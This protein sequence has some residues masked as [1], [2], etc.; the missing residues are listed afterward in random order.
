LSFQPPPPQPLEPFEILS[1]SL[2]WRRHIDR[3]FP[4]SGAYYFPHH[5]T[6]TPSFQVVPLF[7]SF[8]SLPPQP[9]FILLVLFFFF[10]SKSNDYVLL[11]FFPGTRSVPGTPTGFT[12][13]N[14]CLFVEVGGLA[15]PEDIVLPVD[16]LM[17]MSGYGTPPPEGEALSVGF[18]TPFFSP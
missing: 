18:R 2:V 8:G 16:T 4:P 11:L 9:F 12:R 14:F 15:P 7:R 1:L 6:P 3:F 5:S 13:R 17:E 10:S